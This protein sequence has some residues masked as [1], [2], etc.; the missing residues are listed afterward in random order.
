LPEEVAD[1]FM[2]RQRP[3]RGV[4]R[5][6]VAFSLAAGVVCAISAGHSAEARTARP[7]RAAQGSELF[8][9]TC[10]DAR[11]CWAVGARTLS[12]AKVVTL[13]EHWNGVRWSSSG[14]ANPSG[15]PDATLTAVA[16]A[17]ASACLAVGNYQ[18]SG[19]SFALAERWNGSRWSL[20][21]PARPPGSTDFALAAVSCPAA[22]TC[23]AV[24]VNGL[25]TLAERWNGT[26]WRVSGSVSQ[27]TEESGLSAVSCPS[28]GSCWAAGAWF[29]AA[30]SGTLTEHWNG[31]KWALTHTGTSAVTGASLNA[32]GCRRS[33]CM[34]AGNLNARALAER[35]N[36]GRWT[37]AH[38]PKPAGAASARLAGVSC[39]AT[40][41]C[42]AA[43]VFTRTGG[44]KALT[45]RWNGRTWSVVPAPSPSSQTQLNAVACTSSAN[46]W[47]V[48][49]TGGLTNSAKLIEH[50]NGKKWTVSR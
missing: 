17:R 25:L 12:T 26:R 42:M 27:G 10:A 50:W 2:N 39:A 13:I 36:G 16:C 33:S 41:S 19:K 34:A 47:T 22:K 43:G 7:A 14:S 35:L 23:M 11:D 1:V 48:G 28:A 30:T 32:M 44:D 37:L 24:G 6:A 21:T 9:V 8:G 15:S 20:V 4:S 45:E 46:C 5:G 40:S 29:S 38:P 3:G 31:S 49:V 18:H